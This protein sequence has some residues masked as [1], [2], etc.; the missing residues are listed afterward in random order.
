MYR[1]VH[2]NIRYLR[3]FRPLSTNEDIEFKDSRPV[4][5]LNAAAIAPLFSGRGNNS[6]SA[7]SYWST[8]M[9]YLKSHNSYLGLKQDRFAIQLPNGDIDYSVETVNGQQVRRK[10]I[11]RPKALCFDYITLKDD[12][13]IDLETEIITDT[14]EKHIV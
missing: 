2:Y 9:S 6:T 11:N 14:N 12:F 13:G 4:L 8:I 5:S 7:R 1:G 10:K 3:R